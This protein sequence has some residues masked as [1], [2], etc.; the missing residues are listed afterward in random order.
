[1]LH[2]YSS[3]KLHVCFSLY[4]F[5]CFCLV[6]GSVQT[7]SEC[8][9]GSVSNICCEIATVLVYTI[10]A[11]LWFE[12][13]YLQF[14]FIFVLFWKSLTRYPRYWSRIIKCN[15]TIIYCCRL[16]LSVEQHVL[17][18]TFNVKSLSI[19]AMTKL[20]WYQEHFLDINNLKM[21]QPTATDG[22]CAYFSIWWVVYWSSGHSPYQTYY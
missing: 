18:K 17:I 1:M 10:L 14:M 8:S 13:I 21:E 15:P 2:F 20:S 3:F 9:I 5:I 19:E 4:F 22:C 11:V 12:W 16:S 7:G 6:D